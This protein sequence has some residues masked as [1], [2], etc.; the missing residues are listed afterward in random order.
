MVPEYGTKGVPPSHKPPSLK[1]RRSRATVDR[2][3]MNYGVNTVP[4][5][6]SLV[7]FFQALSTRHQVMFLRANGVPPTHKASAYGNVCR[8]ATAYKTVGKQA[9]N[10][11]IEDQFYSTVIHWFL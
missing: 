2:Q 3:G 6:W 10:W 1:L 11:S 7:V 8:P 9:W 5:T 4:S